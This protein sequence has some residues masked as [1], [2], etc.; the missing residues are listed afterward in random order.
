MQTLKKILKWTNKYTATVAV[1]A[2]GIFFLYHQ[3]TRPTLSSNDDLLNIVGRVT[4]YSF[5]IGRPSSRATSKL[6]YIWLDNYPCSFQIKAD[7]LSFFR[8]TLF[9]TEIRKG[10]ELH[11]TI[12]KELEDKLYERGTNI[13]ILSASHNSTNYLSLKDTI[14]KENDNFDIYAGLLFISAGVVYYILKSRAIIK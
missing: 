4:N 14:P 1:V 8:Q 2:V 7:F 3:T 6:Y 11:L 9:E 13:F 10:K 5:K 12:P